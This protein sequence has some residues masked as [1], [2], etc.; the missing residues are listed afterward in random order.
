MPKLIK[1]KQLV[2]NEWHILK[3][4]SELNEHINKKLF[5]PIDTWLQIPNELINKQNANALG[6]WLDSDQ[7]CEQLPSDFNKAAAIAINFPLFTDGRAYSIA[8]DLRVLKH[9]TGEVRAVG[10]VLPDQL[11]A[12]L[13]CGFDA[14]ELVDDKDEQKALLAFNDFT[15]KYQADLIEKRP[16]YSR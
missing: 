5:V 8:K 2:E 16:V 11:N 3:D 15:E 14:F 9:Y 10:D 13:R 6:L 7:S 12:M 4:L 1:N